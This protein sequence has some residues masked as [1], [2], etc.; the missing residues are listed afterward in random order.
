MSRP[1]PH[2]IVKYLCCDK[3]FWSIFQAEATGDAKGLQH[4][5]KV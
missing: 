4:E 1:L 5:S 3:Y 2:K